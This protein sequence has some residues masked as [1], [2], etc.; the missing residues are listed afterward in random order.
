MGLTATL[1]TVF[2]AF[3][4]WIMHSSLLLM[5]QQIAIILICTNGVITATQ[6]LFTKGIAI[7]EISSVK[8]MV[9]C[10]TICSLVP[11]LILPLGSFKNPV[12]IIVSIGS[13]ICLPVLGIG[14]ING[15][16]CYIVASTMIGTQGITG[17]RREAVTT[18]VISVLKATLTIVLICITGYYITDKFTK[19]IF[20]N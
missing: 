12:E 3:I 4:A 8:L 17:A 15:I 5:L 20:R 2:V 7:F 1:I 9:L 14:I 13:V 6:L 11:S 19:L 10:L 18:A 16:V